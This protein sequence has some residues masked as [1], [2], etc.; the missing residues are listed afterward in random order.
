MHTAS[1]RG[2]AHL[3]QLPLAP[4]LSRI[5]PQ[6]PTV[7]GGLIPT[8]SPH[9]TSPRS[10]R[11]LELR[12]LRK[13]SVPPLLEG[14]YKIHSTYG[15]NRYRPHLAKQVATIPA[16][17]PNKYFAFW[18]GLSAH[19]LEQISLSSLALETKSDLRQVAGLW[20]PPCAQV[21]LPPG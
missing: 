8:L 4:S 10:L 7:T 14:C 21:F 12:G 1:C 2:A 3:W 18:T 17:S 13:S 20:V 5:P 15:G 19:R 9:C 16:S 6:Q 11:A